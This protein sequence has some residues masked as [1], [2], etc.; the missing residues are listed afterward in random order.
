MD[1]APLSSEALQKIGRNVVVL[2]KMEGLLKELLV[3]MDVAGGVEELSDLLNERRESISKRSLGLV[4]GDLFDKIFSE[5]IEPICK[6]E[7]SSSWLSF[8]YREGR[9]EAFIESIKKSFQEFIAGRNELIHQRLLAFDAASEDS[10]WELISYLD[11]QYENVTPLRDFL[12][13]RLRSASEMLT[14]IPH[15]I[16]QV[17]AKDDPSE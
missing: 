15:I 3:V 16:K 10:C 11:A 7:P 9:S 1:Q 8:Q 5:P 12:I 17:I 2:Q 6:T 4:A 14:A 13:D